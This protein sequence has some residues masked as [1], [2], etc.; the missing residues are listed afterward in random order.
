MAAAKTTTVASF[1]RKRPSRKPFPEHL[2]RER[3]IVPGPTACLCCGGG[4]TA[5]AG[6]RRH[7]DA[8]GDP[9]PVEGDPA[10]PREVHLPGLREDQPGSG[11]VPCDRPGLGRAQP[12]GDGA[13]R[14]VWPASAAQPASRAL[15][16]GRRADQSVDLGRPGRRLHGGAD[17]FVQAPRGLRPERR[18]IAWGRH[19]GPGPRQRQD[20]H[21]PNLGL[22]ARRQAVWRAGAAGGGV[23]LLARPG[24]RASPGAFGQLHRNLPGRRLW[25]LRQTLRARPLAWAD[26]AKRPVGSMPGVRSS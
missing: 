16:Q 8:G 21:R 4:A 12:A 24:R 17:A 26:P 5:Q 15:C 19:H 23:L 25:R 9:A 3:V 2:P 22:R 7:R 18:A 20:R 10:C 11:A 13:V 1:T 6:R 14:E